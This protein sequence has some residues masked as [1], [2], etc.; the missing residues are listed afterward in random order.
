[1]DYTEKNVLGGL[2]LFAV[3]IIAIAAEI[4]NHLSYPFAIVLIALTGAGITL[5]RA[6]EESIF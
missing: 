5:L 6:K 3:M 4:F 1:L 2:I